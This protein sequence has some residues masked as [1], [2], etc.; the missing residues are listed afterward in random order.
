MKNYNNLYSTNNQPEFYEVNKNYST[1]FP[2]DSVKRNIITYKN[3]TPAQSSAKSIFPVPKQNP[4]FIARTPS[5]S[6]NRKNFININ[7]NTKFKERSNSPV[8]YRKLMETNSIKETPQ[9]NYHPVKN[10]F[11]LPLNLKGNNNLIS[12]YQNS[13]IYINIE[14]K[15]Q[16]LVRTPPPRNNNENYLKSRNNNILYNNKGNNYFPTLN[17]NQIL[18][19]P[20]INKVQNI[21]IPQIQ[22]NFNYLKTEND[23]NCIKINNFNS[24]KKSYENIINIDKRNNNYIPNIQKLNNFNINQN[25]LKNLKIKKSNGIF[26][27][28]YPNNISIRKNTKNTQI[29][30]YQINNISIKKYENYFQNNGYENS[31]IKNNTDIN[32]D[33]YNN[34]NNQSYK[35]ISNESKSNYNTNQNIPSNII[36]NHINIIPIPQNRN[37]FNYGKNGFFRR[38]FKDIL[39]LKPVPTDDFNLSEFKIINL[40][41]EGTFGK[42]YCV[43]WLKN[44]EFYALKKLNLFGDEL[45]SFQKRSKIV[46]NLMKTTGHNGFIKIYGDKIIPKG[47]NEY[48]YYICMELGGRDWEKEILLRKSISLYYSEYELFEIIFQLVKT[49]SLMQKNNV[50]HRDIKPQNILLCKNNI[51]K[52]CDFDEAKIIDSDGPILQPV[53][54]SELYMSPI[55]FYAYNHHISNVLHNTYKSDVFSLG[56]TFFLAASLSAKPL[57]DIRELKDMKKISE[58]I[59]NA[60]IN[61]YSQNL[62]NLIVKTLQIDENLRC[63]FIELEEYISKIWPN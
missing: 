39:L 37:N 36:Q 5:P 22:N 35:S 33:N 60:L 11:Q 20:I 17:V 4:Y 57:C 14:Q 1:D 31:H 42:I 56:M 21:G 47:E 32:I 25:Y 3:I 7:D 49:L 12:F 23:I 55:L 54:G 13:P 26:R 2:N 61:R 50:T 15:N 9:I 45:N 6:Y 41:G 10:I 29:I 43:R 28:K 58:I 59:N 30:N 19:N 46:Q 53:R 44:S 63:D 38:P 52:I 16:R 62:I 18:K 51:F 40:I 48:H 8:I 24:N 34:N 27:N